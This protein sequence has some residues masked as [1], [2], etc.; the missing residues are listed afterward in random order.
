MYTC[1]DGRR[2]ACVCQHGWEQAGG[3]G[4]RFRVG[5][6]KASACNIPLPLAL[7]PSPGMG[8]GKRGSASQD[9]KLLLGEE[10][11]PSIRSEAAGRAC[12]SL[13]QG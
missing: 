6:A 10:K 13:A 3:T 5:K 11:D 7:D 12:L 8:R 2:P 4:S 9:P 1:R